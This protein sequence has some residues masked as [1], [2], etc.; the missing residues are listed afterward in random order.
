MSEM[1]YLHQ[2][3]KKLW[4]KHPEHAESIGLLPT[5][6]KFSEGLNQLRNNGKKSG[7]ERITGEEVLDFIEKKQIHPEFHALNSKVLASHFANYMEWQKTNE[8]RDHKFI[9]GL[10]E[11]EKIIKKIDEKR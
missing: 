7:K 10:E 8:R 2:I 1:P 9:K 6:V 3:Q 5:I 11:L 4:E